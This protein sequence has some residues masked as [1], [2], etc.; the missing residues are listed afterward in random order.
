MEAQRARMFSENIKLENT[1]KVSDPFISV[2]L[3]ALRT[4]VVKNKIL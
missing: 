2:S 3:S 1:S 4:S